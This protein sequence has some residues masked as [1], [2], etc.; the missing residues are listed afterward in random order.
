MTTAAV[1]PPGLLGGSNPRNHVSPLASFAVKPG[2]APAVFSR[3]ITHFSG[4]GGRPM[5]G[6]CASWAA[7]TSV[8]PIRFVNQL[9]SGTSSIVLMFRARV[10]DGL[11]SAVTNRLYES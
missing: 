2:F 3:T 11:W 5:T 4:A 7:V 1:A 8:E 10:F 6:P 9:E